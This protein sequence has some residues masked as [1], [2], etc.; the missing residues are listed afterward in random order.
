MD[1]LDNNFLTVQPK[2]QHE[3]LHRIHIDLYLNRLV[4][5]ILLKYPNLLRNQLLDFLC[6]VIAA[7]LH[8]HLL[9]IQILD[10]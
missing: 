3:T 1:L 7:K 5:R 6:V 8:H 9:D 2:Q 10:P 4:F